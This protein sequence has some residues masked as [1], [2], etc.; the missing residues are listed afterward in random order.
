MALGLGAFASPLD[1]RFLVVLH[2][3]DVLAVQTLTVCAADP[4]LREALAVLG[5]TSRFGAFALDL[6]LGLR[7]LASEGEEI[8][9]LAL[10]CMAAKVQ[11]VMELRKSSL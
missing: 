4:S 11:K 1:V 9:D 5:L 2:R 8:V 7:L 10:S 3:I 6:S